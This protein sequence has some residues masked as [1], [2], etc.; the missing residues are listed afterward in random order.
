MLTKKKTHENEWKYDWSKYFK[1]TSLK[2][3][4]T[5]LTAYSTYD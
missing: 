1:N 5:L 3:L 4:E 2:L